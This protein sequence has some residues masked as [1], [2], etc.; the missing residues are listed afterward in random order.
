M[1]DL[2]LRDLS[3]TFGHVTAVDRIELAVET[4]ELVALLGPSGCGKTTTLRMIAGFV[5]PTGGAILVQGRDITDQPPHRR[6]MGMVFQNYALFPHMTVYRN[7]AF[8]LHA[9]GAS[10]SEIPARV[11]EALEL[12]GLATMVERYPRQLSGG[13]Q[14][15]VAVARILALKPK[16]LLFDEPLSN[17]DAKLRVQMRHEIRR[18][19]KDVGITALFVT[20]DQEEAMTIADRIAVLNEGRI[21]Q[22]GTPAEIYDRPRSRFVA[23]FIGTSNFLDGQLIDGRFRTRSGIDLPIPSAPEPRDAR[24]LSI[25]PERIDIR[26][27]G[28]DALLQGTIVRVTRLGGLLEYGIELPSGET[29][30]VH[31][32]SRPGFEHR[33][34]GASVGLGWRLEDARLFNA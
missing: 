31:E 22:V 18:L 4:G 34:P 13:Q 14:Q 17:L 5:I 15:R 19:Q 32:Q 9:R 1:A 24:V 3:K 29:V 7:I 16:L 28:K 27:S 25:R 12:V 26:Q 33:E 8:G 2:E 10:K 21:E 20:H 6:D 11:T 30:V 23:D